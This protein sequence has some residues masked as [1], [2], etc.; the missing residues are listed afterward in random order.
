MIFNQLLQY[1]DNHG[2]LIFEKSGHGCQTHF[3]G[4]HNASRKPM[5]L[6]L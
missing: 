2:H 6:S 4:V 1:P 3:I 5:S